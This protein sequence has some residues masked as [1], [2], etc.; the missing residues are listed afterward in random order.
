MRLYETYTLETT[1]D[2]HGVPI[3][4]FILTFNDP[5]CTI[6]KFISDVTEKKPYQHSSFLLGRH[7]EIANTYNGIATFYY[8]Y[9][10]DIFQRTMKIGCHAIG[11]SEH[12]EYIIE[13]EG[14]FDG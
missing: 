14:G 7:L 11:N 2:A 6:E 12:M 10:S 3:I 13:M 4:H 9:S 5:D 8:P 1:Y